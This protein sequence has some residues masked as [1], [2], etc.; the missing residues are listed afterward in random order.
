MHPNSKVLIIE[1]TQAIGDQL[2]NNFN[3]EFATHVSE[4]LEQALQKSDSWGPS[5]IIIDVHLAN[6][7]G[8]EICDAFKQ[9][10]KTAEIPIIFYSEKDSLRER[11]L[12]YEVG[13]VDFFHK[14]SPIEEVKAKLN[15]IA[16]QS[17][18]AQALKNDVVSA[19]KT[20]MEALSTSSEL[21][22]AV[23]YVEQSYD[24]G[25]FDSLAQLLTQFC[26]DLDLN[27]VVMFQVRRG[28]YFYASNG[29]NAAPIERDLIE[30][31]HTTDRFVDFGCRTLANY[32]QVSLLVKNMPIDNRERYGRLKDTIP[33]VLGATDAKVRMLDAEGALTAHCASLTSSV[34]AAQ[35]TLDTVQDD[36]K[37]N[38]QIVETIMNELSS[39]MEMDIEK[40]NM[41]ENDENQLLTLVESTSKKLHII[42]QEHNQ[43]D[44]ILADLVDLLEKLTQQQSKIIVETL[45]NKSDE[46][47]NYQTDIELF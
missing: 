45:T 25:E 12:G 44:K 24:V 34:E 36:F 21:G 28:N 4:N 13:A 46:S 8:Y 30:K 2:S 11:M 33:F 38:L 43:T 14:D 10:P 16:K 26:R 42:L 22:K 31:L 9:D 15:A 3:N 37:R 20:A 7:N 27:A 6:R 1:D 39:T 23:R 32:P 29:E 47:M 35:L 40:M 41:D 5:I 19:E 17:Q 18:K